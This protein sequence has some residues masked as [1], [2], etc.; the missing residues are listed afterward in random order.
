MQELIQLHNCLCPTIGT[1]LFTC[2][3]VQ[4]NLYVVYRQ[5]NRFDPKIIDGLDKNVRLG[6]EI[7][8]KRQIS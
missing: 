3:M 5:M 7:E 4:L 1:K 6:L 2:K 8:R